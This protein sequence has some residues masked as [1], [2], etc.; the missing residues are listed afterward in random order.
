MATNDGG[1]VM[2]RVRPDGWVETDDEHAAAKI[3]TKLS[4]DW[5]QLNAQNEDLDRTNVSLRRTEAIYEKALEAIRTRAKGSNGEASDLT[6]SL[7]TIR[8]MAH[9]ALSEVLPF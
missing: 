5:A 2:Y 1:A 3:A 9:D 6:A 4:I 8:K 7:E